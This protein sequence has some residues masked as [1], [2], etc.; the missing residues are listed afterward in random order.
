M[1][2]CQFNDDGNSNNSNDNNNDTG[3]S[4]NTDSNNNTLYTT[5][6]YFL[7]PLW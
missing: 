5:I 1:N 7:S 2:W 3:N 4:N 6:I